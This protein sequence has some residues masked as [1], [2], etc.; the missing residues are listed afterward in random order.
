MDSVCVVRTFTNQAGMF[1]ATVFVSVPTVLASLSR[2][3]NHS[4]PKR[5]NIG[6]RF[7]EAEGKF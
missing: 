3:Q 7:L 4:Q 2:D 5:L 1:W 6:N